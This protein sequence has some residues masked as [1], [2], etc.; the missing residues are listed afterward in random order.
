MDPG[1]QLNSCHLESRVGNAGLSPKTF[2]LT[3]TPFLGDWK[4]LV[5]Q[6]STPMLF[7]QVSLELRSCRG[8]RWYIQWRCPQ[9]NDPLRPLLKHLPQVTT[10]PCR[11]LRNSPGLMIPTRRRS[12][13]RCTSRRKKVLLGFFLAQYP[14]VC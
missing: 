6:N 3:E 1:Y 10:K 8:G 5:F 11:I 9:T 14:M 2:R 12:H 4:A 13:P 7:N